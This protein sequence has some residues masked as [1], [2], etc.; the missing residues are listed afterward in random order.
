MSIQQYGQE[1]APL[2]AVIEKK[3]FLA[4]VRKKKKKTLTRNEKKKLNKNTLIISTCQETFHYLIKII[5]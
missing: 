1:D 3:R 2:T 4:K 5:I